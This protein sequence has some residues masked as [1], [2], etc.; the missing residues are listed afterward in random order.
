MKRLGKTIHSHLVFIFIIL[1][2]LILSLPTLGRDLLSDWDECIYTQYAKTMNISKDFTT[3]YWNGKPALEKPPLNSILMQV[4]FISGI[5]EFSARITT[6]ILGIL[7]LAGVYFFSIKFF[8]KSIAIVSVLVLLS[9]S[10]FL[11]YLVRVNTDIGFSLFIF[12]GLA[13]WLASLKRDPKLSLFSGIF[14]GLA[15]LQKGPGV[16]PYFAGMLIV[17]LLFFREKLLMLLKICFTTFAISLP[18]HVYEY[19]LFGQQFINVYVLENIIKRARYPLEFHMEGRLFYVRLFLTQFNYLLLFPIV[20]AVLL[21]IKTITSKITFK[22]IDLVMKINYVLTSLCVIFIVSFI[23]IT[24]IRTRIAWYSIPLLP[25]GSII[26]GYSIDRLIHL[27]KSEKLKKALHILILV[28]LILQSLFLVIN[29]YSVFQFRRTIS[30]RHEVIIKSSQMPQKELYYLVQYSERRAREMLNE[31]LYTS[32]T[33]IFGG[34]SCALYYSGKKVNYFY[35]VNNFNKRL[36]VKDR[37]YLIENGDYQM[38]EK[39]SP[40]ILF[41]NSDFILFTY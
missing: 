16:V 3:H 2:V 7:L 38:I 26:I 31:N 4:P 11:Y 41:K 37:L 9:S 36:G 21:L 27:F 14:F 13:F 30:P 24:K 22:K 17:H 28:V 35:N 33:W 19:L 15:V 18:W 39:K 23:M 1:S 10:L 5:N 40:R 12:C 6:F 20:G 34:N 29:S 8:S 25:I 32:T